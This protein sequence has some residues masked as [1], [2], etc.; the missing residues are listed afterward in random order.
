[1]TS[2]Q[3]AGTINAVL[4]EF[5]FPRSHILQHSRSFF[6]LPKD[7]DVDLNSITLLSMVEKST[8]IRSEYVRNDLRLVMESENI[9]V[10]I[11]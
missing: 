11:K 4:G 1:M 2:L 8:E 5:V 6:F 7:P 10:S 9:I 3:L